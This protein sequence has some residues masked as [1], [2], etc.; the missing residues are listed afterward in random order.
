MVGT[1]PN[2]NSST[3]IVELLKMLAHYAMDMG[4]WPVRRKVRSYGVAERL[5]G[6]PAHLNP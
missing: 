3:A 1:F 6:M 5:W 2:G 4:N